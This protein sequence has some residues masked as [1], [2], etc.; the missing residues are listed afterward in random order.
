MKPPEERSVSHSMS[1]TPVQWERMRDLAQEAGKQTSPYIVGRVLKRDGL[2]DEET[3]RGH[4]LVLAEG[5]Q[6]EMHDAAIRAEAAISELL[7]LSGGSSPGLAA[8]VAMLFEARLDEM[9]RTG[10]RDE[11]ESLLTSIVGPERAADIVRRVL[12][13][14]GQGR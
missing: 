12:E 4:A 3:G 2:G 7:G 9:A 6:R 13:Q 1:C 10:R 8:T 11:M 5:W 14:P